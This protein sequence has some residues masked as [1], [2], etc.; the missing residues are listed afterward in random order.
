MEF[1]SNAEPVQVDFSPQFP[2]AENETLFVIHCLMFMPSKNSVMTGEDSLDV[3]KSHRPFWATL[4][5]CV[6]MFSSNKIASAWR[7]KRIIIYFKSLLCFYRL[8]F[9]RAPCICAVNLFGKGTI[10]RFPTIKSFSGYIFKWDREVLMKSSFVLSLFL[11]V[12]RIFR[13][14]DSAE[15]GIFF[16]W[17]VRDLLQMTTH[18]IWKESFLRNYITNISFQWRPHLKNKRVDS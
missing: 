9:F 11:N 3:Y 13:V 2:A 1:P 16:S 14:E 17:L 7:N 6:K 12:P 5:H 15:I 4:K 8:S 10:S 18:A